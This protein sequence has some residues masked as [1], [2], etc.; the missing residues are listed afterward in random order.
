MIRSHSEK[1]NSIL[2]LCIFLA[3]LCFYMPHKIRR[4][5]DKKWGS[6]NGKICFR[7]IYLTIFLCETCKPVLQKTEK[8][9][10]H[11]KKYVYI[12][13][14]CYVYLNIITNVYLFI[15]IEK[16]TPHNKFCVYSGLV[17]GL[18]TFSLYIL[19]VFGARQWQSYTRFTLE[20]QLS[21]AKVTTKP[22]YI[23]L[24]M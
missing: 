1:N 14:T 19:S 8:Q 6:K 21:K 5:C 15:F 22:L 11:I 4:M 18:T 12:N 20:I 10:R 17:L 3:L 23:C 2:L 9:A 13:K 16:L 24:H 7:W